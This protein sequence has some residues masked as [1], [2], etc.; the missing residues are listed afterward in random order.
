MSL[1]PE[2][3]ERIQELVAS[4]PVF[5]FMKGTPESPQCGFSAQVVQILGRLVPHYGSFDVLSDA[6]VREGIKEYAQWPTIPQLYVNGEFVGGCDIIKE[7]YESGELQQALGL[8]PAPEA[9]PALEITAAAVE[10]LRAAAQ[11]A[12]GAELHLSID[13]RFQSGLG[14]GPKQPGE[15][16]VESGGLSL[17]L[18]RETARRAD[19]VRIDAVD[20]PQ[21]PQLKIDNPNAPGVG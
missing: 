4:S 18:D 17:H 10:V 8:D 20:T 7:S 3:R 5:L 16:T 19:G 15:L 6:P 9:P 1:S 13:A 2:I 12:G 11:R 21:G 14:L